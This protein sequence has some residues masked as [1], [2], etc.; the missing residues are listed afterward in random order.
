MAIGI[1]CNCGA[2]Y[3]LDDSH[4]GKRFVCKVC[5]AIM[6]VPAGVPRV[7]PS[8]APQIGEAIPIK[9]SRPPAQAPPSQT[10]SAAPVPSAQEAPTGS[11]ES[12]ADRPQPA[13]CYLKREA[14]VATQ[15]V[16]GVRKADRCPPQAWWV[17]RI[18][19]WMLCVGFLFMPWL[20]GSVRSCGMGQDT[21]RSMSVRRI[22]SNVIGAVYIAPSA[23]WRTV[24]N[25]STGANLPP[26]MR[27][28]G[29]GGL[30]MDFGACVYMLGLA[31]AAFVAIIA[32]RHSG[33]G[34]LWPFLIC[35]LGLAIFITGWQLIAHTPDVASV[36]D[37]ESQFG[38]SIGVAGWT[39]VM[40]LALI[41]ICLIAKGKPDYAL[42]DAIRWSRERGTPG[43]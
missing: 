9:T 11:T 13:A 18:V 14:R 4:G 29:V 17:T 8:G 2:E 26:G 25:A 33:R 43:S 39:Y 31:S 40:G 35:W 1:K 34:A 28:V 6:D 24:R 23:L 7:V 20:S 36:L 16:A 3:R 22:V 32:R 30:M 37:A 42:A 38:A 19:M 10:Q 21:S 12:P 15:S 5:Q 27:T 41:P